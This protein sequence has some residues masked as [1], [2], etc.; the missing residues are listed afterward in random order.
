LVLAGSVLATSRA[1]EPVV[2]EPPVL[3]EEHPVSLG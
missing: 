3:P 2:D 1:P